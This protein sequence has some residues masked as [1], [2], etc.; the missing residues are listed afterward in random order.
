MCVSKEGWTDGQPRSFQLTLVL[1]ACCSGH[2]GTGFASGGVGVEVGVWDGG[3][4]WP[5]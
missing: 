5:L 2:I 3:G 4:L 1:C